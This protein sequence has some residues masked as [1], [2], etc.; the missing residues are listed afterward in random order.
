[1]ELEPGQLAEVYRA[2]SS[3]CAVLGGFSIA[4]LVIMVTVAPD[5]KVASWAT[6]FSIVAV[7]CFLPATLNTFLASIPAATAP[8]AQDLGADVNGVTGMS[9][10]LLV[11]GVFALLA[12]LGLTG[13]IRSKRV[14]ILSTVAAILAGLMC[15]RGISLLF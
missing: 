3:I 4:F 7:A 15:W 1:M 9:A 14:G 10:L 6:G 12:S 13:W 11:I 5:R 2:F 8:S